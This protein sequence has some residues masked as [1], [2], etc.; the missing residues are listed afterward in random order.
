MTTEEQILQLEQ[1]KKT[2]TLEK[3][4]TIEIKLRA[5]KMGLKARKNEDKILD[6][7]EQL[8]AIF[9]PF[10]Y[11]TKSLPSGFAIGLKNAFPLCLSSSQI[12]ETEYY[13]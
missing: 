12:L 11:E 3:C 9:P 10:K 8:K 2:A 1:Q 4:E 7:P 6:T 5:L 13:Y